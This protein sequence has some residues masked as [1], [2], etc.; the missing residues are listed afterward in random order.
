MRDGDGRTCFWAQVS[1]QPV[2]DGSRRYRVEGSKGKRDL[3]R[4]EKSEES[5]GWEAEARKLVDR[6]GSGNTVGRDEKR[7]HCW[8]GWSKRGKGG[9]F[10]DESRKQRRLG[11]GES[12]FARGGSMLTLAEESRSDSLEGV[13]PGVELRNLLRIGLEA[14]VD[15]VRVIVAK[16]GELLEDT[17][18]DLDLGDLEVVES[19]RESIDLGRQGI[20]LCQVSLEALLFRLHR[21]NPF[22]GCL[23]SSLK[24]T[25]L[26]S[27]ELEDLVGLRAGITSGVAMT[28]WASSRLLVRSLPCNLRSLFQI[29]NFGQPPLQV[30]KSD[31]I[32]VNAVAEGRQSFPDVLGGLGDLLLEGPYSLL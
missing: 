18:V 30:A 25:E 10:G 6:G 26:S 21:L 14:G 22:F 31:P 16:V 4:D 20:C 3:A 15:A 12:E 5:G 17:E 9:S 19:G 11:G 13:I 1:C 32:D 29:A 24:V 27:A 2:R 28:R 23:N 7:S 8:D